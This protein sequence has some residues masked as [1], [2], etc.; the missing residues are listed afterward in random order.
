MD[1]EESEC[2]LVFTSCEPANLYWVQQSYAE[3]FK[4]DIKISLKK[5]KQ[6]YTAVNNS[7]NAL[8]MLNSNLHL[9]TAETLNRW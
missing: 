8:E 5:K 2:G 1:E 7:K 3:P 9:L 4:K 6:N